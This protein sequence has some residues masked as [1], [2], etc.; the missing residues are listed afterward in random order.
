MSGPTAKVR[1]LVWQR[2]EGRCER[3]FLPITG[4]DHSIHHRRPRG[5]GGSS[6]PATNS[7]ANLLLLCGSGVTG[8]HGWVETH[9]ELAYQTGLLVHRW[10]DPRDV[11]LIGRCL[12]DEGT[13]APLPEAG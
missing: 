2:A 13:Y 7:P 11:P 1:E 10:Q 8:C 9:R 6:D 12:T 3:C 4:G 5:M